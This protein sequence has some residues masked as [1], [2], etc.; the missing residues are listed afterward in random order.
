MYIGGVFVGGRIIVTAKGDE[1]ALSYEENVTIVGK[2]PIAGRLS[3]LIP[4]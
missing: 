3:C 1:C 4:P 2:N